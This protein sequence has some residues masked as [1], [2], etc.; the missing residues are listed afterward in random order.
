MTLETSRAANCY[1]WRIENTL[2]HI[3]GTGKFNWTYQGEW[4]AKYILNWTLHPILQCKII[5]ANLLLDEIGRPSSVAV[6]FV[7]MTC[8]VTHS[9]TLGKKY[10]A[11]L[12]IFTWK[13]SI[14][15]DLTDEIVLDNVSS[16]I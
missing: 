1:V 3:L 11:Y 4:I 8:W 16:Q 7:I 14:F 6:S 2:I 5:A 13:M 9:P 10:D 12:V 15:T